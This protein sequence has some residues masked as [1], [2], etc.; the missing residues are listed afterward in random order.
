MHID[1]DEIDIIA[2]PV[3]AQDRVHDPKTGI[4]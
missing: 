3:T 2:E 4:P 1:S